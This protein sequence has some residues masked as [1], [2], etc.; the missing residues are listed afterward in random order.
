ENATAALEAGAADGEPVAEVLAAAESLLAE[1]RTRSAEERRRRQ[2]RL[3][4]RLQTLSLLIVHAD[5]EERAR[6]LFGR[7]V[8]DAR[9]HRAWLAEW[10]E[11]AGVLRDRLH[12]DHRRVAEAF[13]ATVEELGQSFEVLD[14]R[15]LSEATAAALEELATELRQ[16]SSATGVEARFDAL[17]R[18][19]AL[20]GE[21]EAWSEKAAGEQEAYR[22]RHRAL[23]A[24]IRALETAARALDGFEIVADL[25]E[26]ELA[27]GSAA[28]LEAALEGLGALE[29]RLE[30]EEARFAEACEA[31]R[32]RL[33]EQDRGLASVLDL[34]VTLELLADAA[35][36]PVGPPSGPRDPAGAAEALESARQLRRQLRSSFAAV[37][38]SAAGRRAPAIAELEALEERRLRPGDRRERSELLAEGA[39]LE[40]GGPSPGTGGPVE[41]AEW[42]PLEALLGWL[43]RVSDLV[44][45]VEGDRRRADGRRRQLEARLEQLERNRLAEA[46]P[47]PL[48]ERAHALV[49][50]LGERSAG[51]EPGLESSAPSARP[52]AAQLAAAE[53]LLERLEGHARHLLAVEV[54]LAR[55]R[56]TGDPSPRVRAVLAELAASPGD[57]L[58]PPS[59]RQRLFHLLADEDRP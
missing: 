56:L 11:V 8:E 18:L 41:T 25:A 5:L 16:L 46:C 19:R 34:A 15:L 51:G 2:E 38:E 23:A 29:G 10:E 36:L 12:N 31:E 22:E 48:V 57:E 4:S 35:L 3:G 53:G 30:A 50:G 55:A 1:I 28:S 13:V 59:L 37:S 54:E 27:E 21:L 45:R 32:L 24:K 44:D 33:A 6:A 7:R 40:A 20:R 26:G 49:H 58:P 39:E 47:A 14:R 43:R 52:T 9:A 42:A 17:D